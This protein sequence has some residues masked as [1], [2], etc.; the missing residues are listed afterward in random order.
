M[1]ENLYVD[2]LYIYIYIYIYNIYY[3]YIY[4]YIDDEMEIALV[5]TD[6]FPNF[7][8]SS[9]KFH[10]REVLSLFWCFFNVSVDV[11]LVS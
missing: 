9:L 5:K 8:V 6:Y 3:I 1:H 2:F 4:T 10:Y 7:K 11:V